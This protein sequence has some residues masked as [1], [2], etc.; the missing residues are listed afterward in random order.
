MF[1]RKAYNELLKWKNEWAGKYAVLLEGARRVGKST[2]A[3]NFARNEYKSYILIDFSKKNKK[4]MDCFEDISN[5]DMFFFRLQNETGI[6]LY[7]RESVIIFDEIQLFPPARQAIKHLVKDGRYDYIET[8][9]LISIKKNVKDILI[10][11]EEMKIQV[12]PMDY[13]EFSDAVGFNYSLLNTLYDLKKPIGEATN[14]T[15]IRNFRIYL[16]VGG[17]PQAV[18]AYTQKLSFSQ[19][20]KVK[21]EIINLYEEDLKKIDGSGRLSMIFKSIPSQLVLNKRNFS[22]GSSE[23]KNKTSKDDERIYDLVDSKIVNICYR[24]AEPS[25]SLSQATELNKFRLYLADTGLFVSM[26]FN[27]GTNDYEDIYSK[28]LSNGLNLNLGYL[29]ENAVSQMLVGAN[30]PL[31][32]HTFPKKNSTQHYEIDFLYYRKGKI[33]PLEVKSNK[34]NNHESIDAFKERYSKICG[35][36]YLISSK[37]YKKVDDLINLPYYLLPFYLMKRDN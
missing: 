17:M 11:S 22:F 34:I 7:E 1:K 3:E 37:D 9:S 29:Y 12:N 31:Y 14:R 35:E 32:Y 8:G 21:K 36:R 2:I 4:I 33:S 13:E 23:I 25:I 15:L 20:D 27:N 18:E 19:I 28:L 6:S 24:V 30:C 10:P 26:L 5:L 16:A